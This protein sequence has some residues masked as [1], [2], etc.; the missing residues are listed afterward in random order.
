MV[1]DELDCCTMKKMV[2]EV[3]TKFIQKSGK[4]VMIQVPFHER[5]PGGKAEWAIKEIMKVLKDFEKR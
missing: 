2:L 5:T 1:I 3:P 4:T